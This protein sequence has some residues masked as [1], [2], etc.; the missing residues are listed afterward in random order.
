MT[1]SETGSCIS[2]PLA[3]PSQDVFLLL[4][5]LTI[6]GLMGGL[7]TDPPPFPLFFEL[8]EVLVVSV[9]AFYFDDL[10]SNPAYLNINFM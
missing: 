3:R 6:F 9:L 1:G 8:T 2:F 5:G 4:Y 10:I 7:S